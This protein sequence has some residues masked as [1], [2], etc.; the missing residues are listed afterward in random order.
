MS[1]RR[2]LIR[3]RGGRCGVCCLGW[4]GAGGRQLWE[5]LVELSGRG[6]TLFVTTHYMDE[7]ERCTDVGYIYMSK[8]LVQG[9][10]EELKELPDVTP[11]G[12][13]RYEI[14]VPAATEKLSRLRHTPG[15]L[16]ATLFGQTIHL[17][18]SEKPGEG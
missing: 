2:G 17:L 1:R 10:P 12:T 4:A 3:W 9:K 6:V 11:A 7:A 14:E 5:L 13:R 8:L 15:V 16:D 18:A